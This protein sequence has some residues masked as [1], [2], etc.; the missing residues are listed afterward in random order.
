MSVLRST[1]LLYPPFLL[2][3]QAGLKKCRDAGFDM[4]PFETYRSFARQ[5]ELYMQGRTTPGKIVTYAQRGDSWHH[6]GVA[7]DLALKVNGQWSWQFDPKAISKYFEGLNVT[8]GGPK[9]GPHYQWKKLPTLAEAKKI[10]MESNV[11]G[12]W[13]YLSK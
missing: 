4:H 3:M 7:M 13:H 5:H 1:D 10:M 11:L 6:Y 12:F 8:W 9:D 2:E